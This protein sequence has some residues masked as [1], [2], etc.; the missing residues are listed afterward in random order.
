MEILLKKYFIIFLFLTLNLSGC[1]DFR[2]NYEEVEKSSPGIK[3]PSNGIYGTNILRTSNINII[4]NSEYSLRI[5]KRI[6]EIVKVVFPIPSTGG[7]SWGWQPTRKVNWYEGSG[8]NGTDQRVFITESNSTFSDLPLSFW[9]TNT[10]DIEI[11]ENGE[12]TPTRIK[13][14]GW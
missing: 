7:G 13:T 5:D 4:T 2:G 9:G 10:V 11:Y 8:S 3:Y 14:L 6:G 12:N 1:G